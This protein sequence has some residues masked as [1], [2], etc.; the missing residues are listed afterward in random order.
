[1][2]VPLAELELACA[3]ALS[4]RQG[5]PDAPC[6]AVRDY[7]QMLA[8]Y[9]APLPEIGEPG[10]DVIRD[11]AETATQG[12][13]PM[14]HPRFFGWVLGGSA[15]VGVAADWLVSAWGQNAAFHTSSP[16]V[17]ALEQVAERW[18]LDILD[19]PREAAVGFVTG[20]TVGNF[21]ALA[22]ARGA[23]L[24]RHGWDPDQDGLFG[25]PPVSVFLG[26]DAHTSVFSALGYLGFGRRRVQRI[27]TDDQGRMDPSDLARQMA[28]Q[29]GPAVIIA[30]AGQINTGAFDSF[31]PIADIAAKHD[32]WLHVDAA[33]GLWARA[34][35]D[36][37]ALTHGIARAQSWAVDG[38]KWLQTPFDSGYAIVRDR[39]ALEAA[40][41]I[42]AS[43][44]PERVAHDRIPSFLVP[45]LSRRARGVPTYAMLRSLG[46]QG[47]AD[48]VARH[49]EI[50][51]QIADLLTSQPG[52]TILNDVNLNQIILRFGA[53]TGC[54]LAT[55]QVIETLREQGALFAGGAKWRDQWVLRLS[56][57]CEATAVPDAN[58]VA[59]AI[60]DAWAQVRD[61][62]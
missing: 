30:Q 59:M 22:A 54:D 41:G 15:P 43:Y 48:M 56:V 25:A 50:A 32:A 34:H 2:S 31:D 12:L 21:T 55:E 10:A 1:M 57:I 37:R 8:L 42:D 7:A 53:G 18:L 23:L 4:Y 45:E 3:Q 28:Q 17:S 51:R 9:D 13:T 62:L 14:A 19:L 33:F 60:L 16:T 29:P 20:A 47:V 24:R 27:A 5:L 26:D 6:N 61:R 46:R 49:C 44:L 58:P 39:T 11:L 35:P 52:I 40:M 38:H 36:Y